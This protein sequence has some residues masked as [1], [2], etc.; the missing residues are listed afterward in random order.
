VPGALPTT[1]IGSPDTVVEQVRR[2][3][4]EIG[5]GV[6]DLSLQPP[7]SG[8]P[9]LLMRSLEL[10]GKV[11]AFEMPGSGHSAENETP[12]MAALASTTH[13]RASRPAGAAGQLPSFLPR[14][15]MPSPMPLKNFPTSSAPSFT[16]LP[17][18]L[19]PST[20][21]WAPSSS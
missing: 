10:F 15:A 14:S 20:D 1:F 12:G 11:V 8:D 9:D 4:E 13:E 3:R 18:F 16:P 6:L 7:G 21:A 5:A 2:C 19:R 17:A